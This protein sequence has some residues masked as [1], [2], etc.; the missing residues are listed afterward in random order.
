MIDNSR[1]RLRDLEN[2]IDQLKLMKIIYTVKTKEI[3]PKDGAVLCILFLMEATSPGQ[4]AC[5]YVENTDRGKDP[6]LTLSR[7]TIQTRS[8]F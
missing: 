7:N 8:N 1:G 6:F 4:F 5:K 3:F 2:L